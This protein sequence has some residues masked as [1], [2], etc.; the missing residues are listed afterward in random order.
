[1]GFMDI[2]GLGRKRD[3]APSASSNPY[4]SSG[5]WKGL[6]LPG[7]TSRAG[8]RV[9]ETSTLSIP[10]TM[11][12]L[13]VLCGVF[14]ATPMHY[15]ERRPEGRRRADDGRERAL[16]KL[17]YQQPNRHQS[18]FQFREV[19]LADLLLAGNFYAYVSR[20]PAGR[21]RALTRLRPQHVAIAEFFSRSDGREL[22]YDATLPDGI[23]E[24]FSS[25][26]IWH[27]AGFTRD[28]LAG[29][30]PINFARDALGGAIA[31]ADHAARFWNSGQRPQ[32]VLTAEG[33]IDADTK[34]R[35]RED[36]MARFSG[37]NADSV[38]VLDQS[39]K[40]EFLSNTNQ[41]SQYLETRGFQV[42]DLC[43]VWGVPPHL[44]F[45]LDRATFSNIEHQSLEFI[46]FHMGPHYERVQQS[47]T[48]QFAQPNFYF[49]HMTDAL[50]KGDLKSRMEAYWL[51]RQMG[52]VNA[53]DL[54]RR[55]NEPAI[56]GD[57][58]QEYWRP[59]N[60]GV[61]GEP[62]QPPAPRPTPDP[63]V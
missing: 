58:G 47:A 25:R 9:D 56:G 28:G 7:G 59:G 50:V 43:R 23:R 8:I 35:I 54:R 30:V 44:I 18:A 3:A 52:I 26:D 19:M 57:A 20:D 12:A 63:S 61:A 31:T 38:A 48:I 4:E 34:Q 42:V 10:A 13:R 11:A 45:H 39:L 51:Q 40:P 37:P 17:M 22:F 24:R 6:V 2:L 5:Q 14:A 55:E 36:W 60:M 27:I 33:K 15:Y 16:W 32:T 62:V 46:T 1:M 41:E 53:D 49:E 21:P 29:I